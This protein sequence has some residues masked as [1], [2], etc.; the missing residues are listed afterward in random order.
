V[1]QLCTSANQAEVWDNFTSTIRDVYMPERG[2]IWCSPSFQPP[3]LNS[4]FEQPSDN[5]S[6]CSSHSK[7]SYKSFSLLQG[8]ES[9]LS[10]SSVS[11]P[12]KLPSQADDKNIML[13][14]S[15]K[16]QSMI[17]FEKFVNDAGAA[18]S[19]SNSTSFTCPFADITL[20]VSNNFV[21]VR[22]ISNT[23]IDFT[24]V[25]QDRNEDGRC[26]GLFKRVFCCFTNSKR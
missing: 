26:C 3:A 2:D 11:L 6:Q 18:S 12:A 19:G 4:D 7:N 25:L 23:D 21:E 1:Y 8:F 20:N 5:I 10:E 13:K 14:C 22:D 9:R 15:D 24:E 17:Q 16:S